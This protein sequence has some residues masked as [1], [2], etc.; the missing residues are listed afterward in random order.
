M[1]VPCDNTFLCMG[2]LIFYLMTLTLEF[3][4]N[5]H[6]WNLPR[7]VAFVFHERILLKSIIG[8][9]Y[10]YKQIMSQP[11]RPKTIKL[12]QLMHTVGQK[13]A[14]DQNTNCI[15]RIADINL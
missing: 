9:L 6:N 7:R 13:C 8:Y 5:G 11:L 1:Y 3:Y 10:I 12:C 4:N 14:F 15:L 2:T